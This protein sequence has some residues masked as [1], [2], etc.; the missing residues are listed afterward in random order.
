[1]PKRPR[2]IASKSL[3]IRALDSPD[4][5]GAIEAARPRS[6]E[7]VHYLLTLT[8]GVVGEDGADLFNVVI[9]T[10]EALRCRAVDNRGI[11]AD[12]ATIIVRE[13]DWPTIRSHLEAILRK[14]DAPTMSEATQRLHRYF[15]WEY[16]DY[17]T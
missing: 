15:H 17:K 10:P 12:R 3:E 14:C 11:L 4:V 16:E 2:R 6:N 1:M 7:E 9:A 8:I 5:D 13:F